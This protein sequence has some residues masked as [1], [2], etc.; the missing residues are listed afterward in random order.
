MPEFVKIGIK[1]DLPADGEAKEFDVN[2]TAVCIASVDGS[3]AALENMCCHQ[4]GPLGQGVVMDGR[5]V[6]PWHGW[7][8]DPKTGAADQSPRLSVKV[9]SIRLEGDDV[10]VELS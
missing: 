3:Y 6:C 2:G 1:S 5:V 8:F 7:A 10:L 4:G 9:Y